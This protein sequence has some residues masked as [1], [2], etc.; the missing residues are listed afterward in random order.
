[1]RRGGRGWRSRG[2]SLRA[3]QACSC[4][5]A[6]RASPRGAACAGTVHGASSRCA[7]QKRDLE[8]IREGP[9][10]S[11]CPPIVAVRWG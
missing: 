10:G 11:L 8:R 5:R 2:G 9:R 7:A 6:L 3:C 1:M 4:T